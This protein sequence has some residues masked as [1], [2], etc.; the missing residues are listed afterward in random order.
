MVVFVGEYQHLCGR[1]TWTF[2]FQIN[3]FE[4]LRKV[5]F[6]S[7]G[8]RLRLPALCNSEVVLHFCSPHYSGSSTP[9]RVL[10]VH[11]GDTLST[12]SPH[13]G[14]AVFARCL[15]SLKDERIQASKKLKGPQSIPFEGDKKSFLEDIR[16]VGCRP[17]GGGVGEGAAAG[18]H[19]EATWRGDSP[20]LP[21]DRICSLS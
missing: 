1:L 9:P 17:C 12:P 5:C 20:A 14:E 6:N 16:K 2:N 7:G 19:P 8:L 4:L 18:E 11:T 10:C 21:F 3:C 13:A 15:S